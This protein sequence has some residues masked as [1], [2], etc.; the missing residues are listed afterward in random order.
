MLDSM[1]A[2]I[3]A[4]LENIISTTGAWGI[5]GLMA[6]ESCNIP[7]PSEA[8]LPFAGYLVS[9][10]EMSFHVVA[11]ASAFGCLVG[12]FVSYY[13]G[14]F[15]GRQFLEK[16][17]KYFLVAKEDLDYADK[18][19]QKYGDW[20]FFIC[21]MLPI[22][23][24]FISLPAGILR[25]KKRVFFLLTFL[26]SLIWSYPLIFVGVK[27]GQ[28]LE[29]VLPLWHKFDGVIIITCLVLGCI[30]IYKHVKKLKNS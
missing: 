1:L 21:R 24:T 11:W 14:Y 29:K 27:L 22:I 17:G 12:S 8:T 16:Y 7:I 26:G 25:A 18:W 13:I 5:M 3:I 15:G 10:G 30:Y 9:K 19:V 4:W 23:R 6:L 28:N 20:A 2:G